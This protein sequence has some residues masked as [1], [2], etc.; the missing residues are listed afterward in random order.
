MEIMNNHTDEEIVFEEKA[1]QEKNKYQVEAAGVA[2]QRSRDI[3]LPV[4]IVIAAVLI[5]GAI[6]FS[7]FYHPATAPA[8]GTAATTPGAA[9]TSLASLM[10]LGPRDAILGNP[11]APVT[12]IEYG[13]YQ[14]TFCI[15]YFAT[16][17]PMIQSQ[18]IDTGKAKMVFRDFPFIGPESLAAAN[19]AQCAEDQ[20]KFWTYHDALYAAKVTD[21]SQVA[22]SENDGFLS[23]TEL[24][25]LA[26]QVGLDVPSF[27][28]CLNGS[29]DANYINS[30]RSAAVAA[31]IESTPTTIVNGQMAAEPDGS[32]AGADPTAV[33]QAIANAVAAAGK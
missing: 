8:G 26:N 2:F 17:Q 16:V 10:T 13:D 5:G 20:G 14:C 30:E 24:V 4:S 27:T 32:S 18:F 29:K 28:S 12:I 7:I 22:D 9:T 23:T 31:G 3:F 25:K 11:N 21:A 15:R 33:I 6:I 1:K 19:A